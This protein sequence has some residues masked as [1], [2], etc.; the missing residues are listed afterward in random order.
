MKLRRILS[1]LLAVSTIL[2]L[3]WF[4]LAVAAVLLLP[5][6]QGQ[7]AFLFAGCFIYLLIAHLLFLGSYFAYPALCQ[8]VLGALSRLFYSRR[9]LIRWSIV[10]AVAFSYIVY[11]IYFVNARQHS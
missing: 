8:T 11:V 6:F 9:A 3:L 4:F 2:L 1:W 5:G 7:R 10:Y